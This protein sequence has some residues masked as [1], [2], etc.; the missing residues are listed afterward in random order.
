MDAGNRIGLHWRE[1]K[2]AQ[3]Q[4]DWSAL[5]DFADQQFFG[6]K[7]NRKFNNWTY[8]NA[9]LPFDWNMPDTVPAK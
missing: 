2:H 7:S 9:T 8:P 5:L 1:G 6:R 3:N 4:E